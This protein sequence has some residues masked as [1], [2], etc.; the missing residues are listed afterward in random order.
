VLFGVTDSSPTRMD[1]SVTLFNGW[2]LTLEGWRFA[3][4]DSV[5]GTS[6]TLS[7]RV[8]PRMFGT[9]E[10]WRN[11]IVINAEA[12]TDNTVL[13]SRR[14]RQFQLYGLRSPLRYRHL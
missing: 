13:T 1:G 11:G 5:H 10:S 8:A 6:F 14:P 3:D 9:P 12:V 7:T 4:T 2:S